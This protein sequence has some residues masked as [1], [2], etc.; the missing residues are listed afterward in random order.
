MCFKV[1]IRAFLLII[2]VFR[3]R[4]AGLAFPAVRDNYEDVKSPA[5]WFVG[6]KVD[7]LRAGCGVL[8]MRDGGRYIGDFH[9]NKSDGYGVNKQCHY[10][11]KKS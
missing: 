5:L 7:G 2:L 3:N 10:V 1:L 8:A 11:E 6:G 4:S 9:N